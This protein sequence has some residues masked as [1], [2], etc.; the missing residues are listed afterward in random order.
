MTSA[1]LMGE[2]YHISSGH[3]REE[4]DDYSV[5]IDETYVSVAWPHKDKNKIEISTGG[6]GIASKGRDLRVCALMRDF[7]EAL[8]KTCNIDRASIKIDKFYSRASCE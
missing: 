2:N 6:I 3:N 8:I 5:S 1:K 4:F 7:E